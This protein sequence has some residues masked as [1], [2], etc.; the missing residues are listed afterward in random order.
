MLNIQVELFNQHTKTAGT[1]NDISDKPVVICSI[2][3]PLDPTTIKYIKYMLSEF[4]S[5]QYHLLFL[6]SQPIAVATLRANLDQHELDKLQGILDKDGNLYE[7]FNQTQNKKLPKRKLMRFWLFQSV[8]K[9][10][11]I[12]FFNEQ[13]T[14][15]RIHEAKKHVTQNQMQELFAIKKQN[16]LKMFL[17]MPE[18]LVY[19]Q[20]SITD[21][22]AHQDGTNFTDL[23]IFKIL[24][25]YN[26]WPSTR[27]T[28]FL[29]EV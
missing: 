13:P 14:E 1:L 6:T 5:E 24:Y 10:G 25:Y 29:K 17:D 18:E 26:V 23:T 7:A 28:N 20:D 9:D 22:A 8:I 4:G 27:L 2:V 11:N 12:V 16:I 3:R 15:N 21:F 19:D